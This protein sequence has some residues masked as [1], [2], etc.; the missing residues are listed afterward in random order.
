MGVLIGSMGAFDESSLTGGSPNPPSRR[1]E[2][3]TVYSGT[4]PMWGQVGPVPVPPKTMPT[5]LL[6]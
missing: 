2:G 5:P 6:K 1:G 3:D 4:Y